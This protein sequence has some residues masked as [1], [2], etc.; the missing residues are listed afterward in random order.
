MERLDLPAATEESRLAASAAL[1]VAHDDDVSP[2]HPGERAVQARVGVREKIEK[3]ARR[4]IRNFMPEQHREFFAQLPLFITAW[5]D[6]R[7]H[8]WASALVG[9]PGFLSTPDPRLLH[10]TT[11]PC[12]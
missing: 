6:E 7:A 4:G 12:D 2:F 1:S 11:M 8:P 5:L 10:V 3:F 9:A